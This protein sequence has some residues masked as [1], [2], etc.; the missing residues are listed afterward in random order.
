MLVGLL[1]LSTFYV[2]QARVSP[3][4][5]QSSV[6]RDAALLERAWTLPVAASFKPELAWQ[7][8]P[9]VCGP[10][11]LA[12]AFRS[13]GE[14]VTTES[15]ILSGSGKCWF[16]ICI[17]GLT[18]D[19]LAEVARTHTNRKVTVLRDLSPE[20]FQKHL[21]SGNDPHRRY[22]VNFAREQ[23]FGAGVGHFRR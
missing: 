5:I 10:A 19:Q 11:S 6:V 21:R 15:A 13:L 16:G 20:E 7:S 23:I 17:A 18:L 1:G 9:S 12:N 8:N 14:S 22:I 3:E 2:L 4:A